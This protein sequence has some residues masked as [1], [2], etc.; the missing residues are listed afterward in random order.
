MINEI[1]IKNVYYMILYAFDKVKKNT[2]LT[3]VHFEKDMTLSHVII[4]LF[5]E[6][7]QK[8]T[9]K[10]IYRSYNLVEDDSVYIKGKIQI[11]ES[12]KLYSIKKRIIFEEF[13]ECNILNQIL[14]YTLTNLLYSDLPVKMKK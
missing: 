9:K 10:S 13:N 3:D 7:V 14:K 11:K 1:P 4:E 12:M 6:E 2:I 5:I 8:I